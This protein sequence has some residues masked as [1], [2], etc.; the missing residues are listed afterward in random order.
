MP[1][2]CNGL[3]TKRLFREEQNRR[4]RDATRVKKISPEVIRKS[5]TDLGE[6]ERALSAAASDDPRARRD[7]NFH[8]ASWP[9]TRMSTNTEW[10]V[11]QLKCSLPN[12]AKHDSYFSVSTSRARLY[13]ATGR[14]SPPRRFFSEVHPPPPRFDP[15]VRI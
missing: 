11:S 8:I 12:W 9:H 6:I 13:V 15:N 5:A 10:R 14:S 1:S 7:S 4:R 3:S 2:T